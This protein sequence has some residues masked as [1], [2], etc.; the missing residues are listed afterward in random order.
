M[1]VIRMILNQFWFDSHL[2][3]SQSNVKKKICLLIQTIGATTIEQR[4]V[5]IVLNFLSNSEDESTLTNIGHQNLLLAFKMVKISKFGPVFSQKWKSQRFIEGNMMIISI[6][7]N[8]IPHMTLIIKFFNELRVN[9]TK[10]L[11]YIGHTTWIY[12]LS[13]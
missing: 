11:L 13:N 8:Q 1:K 3:I 2:K 10:L 7:I 5:T 9:F 6:S 4:Y 12:C